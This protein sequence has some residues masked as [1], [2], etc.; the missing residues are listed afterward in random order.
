MLVIA[1]LEHFKF[2]SENEQDAFRP[3]FSTNADEELQSSEA[4]PRGA[5]L[6]AEEPSIH[7][8]DSINIASTPPSTEEQPPSP[9]SLLP[10]EAQGEAN[11][12]PL[13]CCLGVMIGM[14]LSLSVAILSQVFATP[15]RAFFQGELSLLVRILMGILAV[16]FA[17][18]FG[19]LG[20]KVGKKAYRE[21][22]PPVVKRRQRRSRAKKPQ[23]K[24]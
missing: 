18:I 20:W 15:L 22:E 16:V 24:A 12:G 3:D 11:G 8:D 19:Y 4:A 14:L 5:D 7:A 23:Q 6:S 2:M 10:P 17:I 1:S 13:G 9:E 21:Y